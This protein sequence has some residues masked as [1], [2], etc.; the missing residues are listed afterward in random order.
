VLEPDHRALLDRIAG[1]LGTSAAPEWIPSDEA[2]VFRLGDHIVKVGRPAYDVVAREQVV[3]PA[4]R[5]RGF[6]ELPEVVLTQAH[7]DD[8]DVTFLVTPFVP[9]RPLADIWRDDPVA[10]EETA[11]AVGRFLRRLARLDW[12]RVPGAVPAGEQQRSHR[13]WMASWLSVLDG[14]QTDV[15]AVF[16]EVPR[17]FGGWQFCQVR[18]LGGPSFTAIDW[19]AM[20]AYW[21]HC[22]VVTTVCQLEDVAPEVVD[23]FYDGYGPVEQRRLEPWRRL[24]DA[25][26]AAGK[27]RPRLRPRP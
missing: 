7:L 6:T 22:D 24:W 23:A 10:A 27:I 21:M 12:R 25:F 5:Y 3:F 2:D 18:T 14:D 13:G 9:S 8:V 19:G 17:E 1:V 26:D 15:L 4:L 16:D 20:G 11:I